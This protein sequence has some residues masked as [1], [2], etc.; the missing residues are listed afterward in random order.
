MLINASCLLLIQLLL[1]RIAHSNQIGSVAHPESIQDRSSGSDFEQA[2]DDD[3]DEQ[4]D[5]FSEPEY[6]FAEEQEQDDEDDLIGSMSQHGQD[7]EDED[8]ERINS[9]IQSQ[10][11]KLNLLTEHE[12]ANHEII[13]QTDVTIDKPMLSS[14]QVV[15]RYVAN[16]ASSIQ[17]TAQE[18]YGPN[19]NP[20]QRQEDV[21]QQ[22]N[23]KRKTQ[24]DLLNDLPA[25]LPNIQHSDPPTDHHYV[26]LFPPPY[27]RNRSTLPL[28]NLAGRRLPFHNN[29]FVIQSACRKSRK[30]KKPGIQSAGERAGKKLK[31]RKLRRTQI[32]PAASTYQEPLRKKRKRKLASKLEGKLEKSKLEESKLEESKLESKRESK[33]VSKRPQKKE[34]IVIE[35]D[36]YVPAYKEKKSYESREI[37]V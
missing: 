36:N 31:K 3:D 17:K 20:Y 34:V 24:N 2:V 10:A 21:S 28:P 6:D 18:D 8:L 9:E 15:H 27:P 30:R 1:H 35:E 12:P 13:E 7:G 4:T 14:D 32:W 5:E 25:L 37:E 16:Q 22:S 33:R 19:D 29:I 26:E 11:A 23:S